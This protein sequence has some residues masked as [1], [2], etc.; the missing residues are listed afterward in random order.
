MVTPSRNSYRTWGVE[1][2]QD[3]VQSPLIN[4]GREAGRVAF[5]GA[6]IGTTIEWV[7]TSST[8]L[9]AAVVFAPQFFP[10]L[11][12]L[13]GTPLAFAMFAV[14][15]ENRRRWSLSLRLPCSLRH[16]SDIR[17][18]IGSFGPA[19]Y[20]MQWGAWPSVP[21]SFLFFPLNRY[22]V[23]SADVARRCAEFGCLQGA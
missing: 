17:F 2:L 8:A 19:A 16:S 9:P 15:I 14:F 6:A 23:D 22:E 10:Q 20:L 18:S 11:S 21:A 12:R 3:R 5:A 1:W 13:A 7:T 4:R